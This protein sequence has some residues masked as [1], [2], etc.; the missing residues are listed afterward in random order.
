MKILLERTIVHYFRQYF[1]NTK[2]FFLKFN[3][4][5]Q[6]MREVKGSFG[7]IYPSAKS[8]DLSLLD[9]LWG[10]INTVYTSEN[11]EFA[12]IHYNS[13]KERARVLE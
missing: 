13:L 2:L 9:F 10:S 11:N 4:N 8:P 6:N 5:F 12:A 7:P 1:Y 3:T